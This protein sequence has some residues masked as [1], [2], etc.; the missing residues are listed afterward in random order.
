MPK[1]NPGKVKPGQRDKAIERTG[2]EG[3]LET[4][5]AV[6]P[7]LML[8]LSSLPPTPSEILKVRVGPGPPKG[9]SFI[10]RYRGHETAVHRWR[11]MGHSNTPQ[12]TGGKHGGTQR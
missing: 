6:W 2:L 12:P 3:D 10:P 11:R 5:A 8:A 4:L 1:G 7:Q 9:Y